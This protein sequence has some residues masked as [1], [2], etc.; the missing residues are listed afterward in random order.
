MS[1]DKYEQGLGKGEANYAQLSPINFLERSALVYPGK[2]AVVHGSR[3]YT[4]GELFARCKRLASALAGRGV[5]VGD[6]VSF[7][8]TN[9]PEMLEAH[10]GVGMV[11]A[12]IVDAPVAC[13]VSGLQALARECGDA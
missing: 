5:G 13:F 8:A 4:Y 11:G 3:S 10:Y 1:A 6:T 7:M 9:T 12:G 2:T